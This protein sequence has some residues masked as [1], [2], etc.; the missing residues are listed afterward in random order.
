M[1][2]LEELKTATTRHDV[3][4]ILGFKPK[5]LAY[6]L[7]HKKSSNYKQFEI[8]KRKGGN[9]LISAPNPELKKLQK[10]LS[11]LLQDC[12]DEINK[13]RNIK[14]A[15]SHG[16]RRKHSIITNAY[17]HRKQ[18][19]V[20]NT[21]LEN[22]FGMINF[23]RVRGFFISNQN[24]TLNPD[25]ATVLAQI[26]CHENALPQGSPCSPVISNLIGHI[27]DIR[28]AAL[29]NQVGCFYSR[30]ADDL[31]FSTSKRNFPAEVAIQFGEESNQWQVGGK[32]MR[33]VE[34]IGFKINSAKTRMQYMD[35]R[36]DVT[37]L[38]VNSKVN[39]RAEY[40]HASRAM[41]HR[42][43]NTGVFQLKEYNLDESG[44]LIVTEVDGTIEQLNGILSFI[45]SV[46]LI[47]KR[48]IIEN[49]GKA[50]KAKLSKSLNCNEHVYRHFLFSRIFMCPKNLW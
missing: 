25:V 37:G 24:F 6:I 21:D 26:A 30:Y 12:I 46:N 48:K 3:A 39:T 19:Y 38:V 10:R 43:L 22:F 4:D 15:I 8:P 34:K 13:S 32:L 11:K 40:R 9:R 41:V 5:A 45:D 35:S 29:A 18:R 31:T 14:S 23:G 20:F 16:F 33:I 44:N 49:S 2:R 50:K 27:L 42:L 36:Q 47:N 17:V 7:F 1:S 28:L